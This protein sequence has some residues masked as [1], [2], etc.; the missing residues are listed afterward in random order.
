MDELTQLRRQNRELSDK[1]DRQIAAWNANGDALT[2]HT[3]RQ[4]QRIAELEAQVQH[5]E[6][7]NKRLRHLDS[8]PVDAMRRLV[9]NCE[10]TL[11]EDYT[12]EQ[13]VVDYG[14]AMAHF[15]TMDGAA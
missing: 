2:A 9:G 6:Q 1:L 10:W 14:A 8:M 12:A 13:Y 7:D 15:R 4:A 11:S 5:L 3:A